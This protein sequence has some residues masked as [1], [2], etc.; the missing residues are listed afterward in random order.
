MHLNPSSSQIYFIVHKEKG[1]LQGPLP[2]LKDFVLPQ[3][4][5][6]MTEHDTIISETLAGNAEFAQA[7]T[8]IRR[9]KENYRI[10]QGEMS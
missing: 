1:K 9:R 5:P 3:D 10:R 8:I 4:L 6:S 7:C 2:S